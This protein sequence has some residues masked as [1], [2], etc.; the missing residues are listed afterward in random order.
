MGTKL[1]HL[2]ANVVV[3]VAAAAAA[4][5]ADNYERHFRYIAC[6]CSDT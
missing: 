3:A 1:R 2:L 5:V 6:A 4:A